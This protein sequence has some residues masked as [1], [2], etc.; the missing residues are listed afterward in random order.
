M[1]HKG[2]NR[3][4]FLRMASAAALAAPALAT[5]SAQAVGTRPQVIIIGAGIGGIAAGYWLRRFGI[6]S[7]V[8]EA[9]TRLGGRIWSSKL[10]PEA[11]TDLGASFIHDS[12][13][14]PLT[15]LAKFFK[16]QTKELDYLNSAFRRP[17]GVDYTFPELVENAARFGALDTQMRVNRTAMRLAGLPDEPLS[18]QVDSILAGL[19]L[20][21]DQH[22]G[23]LALIDLQYRTHF[24][25]ELNDLSLYHFDQD[26]N[27]V[28]NHDLVF[29]GG[30][31]QLVEKLAAGLDI[32]LG[33]VVRKVTYGVQGVT[34]ETDKGN[35][36]GKYVIVALPLGVLQGPGIEF[37]PLLPDWKRTVINRLRTSKAD[38]LVLRFP[39][40][41]WD[42]TKTFIIR[43]SPQISDFRLWFNTFPLANQPVLMVFAIGDLAAQL[44]TL[45]DAEVIN[46]MM[47]VLRQWYPDIQV[48]EPTGF[49]RSHWTTDPFTRGSWGHIPVGATGV[50]YDI[51]ALPVPY[52]GAPTSLASNRVFFAGETTHRLHPSSVWGAYESGMR[53][54]YR[55]RNL[56]PAVSGF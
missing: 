31:V 41:F 28:G 26:Q 11:I 25:S 5:Q 47:T 29:P 10:W 40:P 12:P 50:E 37:A 24:G 42:T 18:V 36:T 17:N 32:K 52:L 13:S 30:Y 49:Q 15:P 53:E 7:I 14:S 21:P 22:A 46:R 19:Q 44:A 45:P 43:T 39:F 20:P 48:P 55:I 34:V 9:R 35:F 54:A 3:R 16:I 33:H 4:H 23:V 27:V 6:K 1:T 51:M 2:V 56:V 8:L 38:K